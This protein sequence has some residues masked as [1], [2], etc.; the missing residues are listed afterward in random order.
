MFKFPLMINPYFF[1][2]GWEAPAWG[3][4][5]YLSDQ[6]TTILEALPFTPPLSY[7]V[8]GYSLNKVNIFLLWNFW[9]WKSHCLRCS[10]HWASIGF[11]TG[12]SWSKFSQPLLFNGESPP[13]IPY[14]I[15]LFS[16]YHLLP[17]NLF[18]PC[19]QFHQNTYMNTHRPLF[20]AFLYPSDNVTHK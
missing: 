3:G 9:I 20:P 11:S 15:L 7:W 14:F 5:H 6:S 10:R 8:F 4:P 17:F 2:H 13:S 1:S 16:I 19:F 12:G 18:V